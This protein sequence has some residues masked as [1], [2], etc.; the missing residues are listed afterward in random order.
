LAAYP[1][2][3]ELVMPGNMHVEELLSDLKTTKGSRFNAAKRLEGRDSK[4]ALLVAM[5]SSLVIALTVLPYFYKLPAIVAAD[6][7]VA[8][9]I[10]S[11]LILAISLFQ[12]S[13]S[14]AVVAEQHHRCA[15]EVNEIRH[16]LRN[17]A[18]TITDGELAALSTK[19]DHVL[20]KYSTNHDDLDF[21]KY[22]IEHLVD[23]PLSLFEQFRIRVR[24][25]ISGNITYGVMAVMVGFFI[26]VLFWHVA[27]VR[28]SLVSDPP[29]AS[30]TIKPANTSP[31]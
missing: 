21:N 22:Q 16:E 20:S 3:L 31:K 11:V 13:A 27:P 14:D 2:G 17:K 10:M 9:L 19:Y 6:L 1:F 30:A 23:H 26:W 29:T 12:Y 28:N 25:L 4:M 7:S 15:L 18:E 8:T 5:A 24:L